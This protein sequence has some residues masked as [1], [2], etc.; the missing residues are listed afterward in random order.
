MPKWNS[1][2]LIFRYYTINF[3]IPLLFVNI[4]LDNLCISAHHHGKYSYIINIHFVNRLLSQWEYIF[5]TKN[6][7]KKGLLICFVLVTKTLQGEHENEFH[8]VCKNANLSS[9][10]KYY[11]LECTILLN[12]YSI[13]NMYI[14][15]Q[16]SVNIFRTKH[17]FNSK[18]HFYR[19]DDCQL[20]V[21]NREC[22]IL[23]YCSS[24]ISFGSNSGS[25][26]DLYIYIWKQKPSAFNPE[27]WI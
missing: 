17:H 15:V 26:C 12:L 19:V 22:C 24:G 23:N 7:F 1:V 11:I 25:R 16:D 6:I 2:Y 20:W 18:F 9:F 21:L 13:F 14:F 5:F 27:R 10:I 4:L 8:N 3:S